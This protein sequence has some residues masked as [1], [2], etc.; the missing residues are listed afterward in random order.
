MSFQV[1]GGI[2]LFI[3]GLQRVFGSGS[4]QSRTEPEHDMAVFSMG[5]SSYC[6]ARCN[7]G[8]TLIMLGVLTVTLLLLLLANWIGRMIGPGGASI[9]TRVM[10]MILAALSRHECAWNR[11]MDRASAIPTWRRRCKPS[12]SCVVKWH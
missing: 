6:N 5:Y 9:L 7:T 4:Q 8:T 12:V 10:D 2:I 1:G 11:K 3:F